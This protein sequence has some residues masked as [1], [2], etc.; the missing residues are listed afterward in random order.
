L[1]PKTDRTGRV[2]EN[3]APDVIEC[4]G[5]T[6]DPDPAAYEPPTMAG[7]VDTSH[8]E[9]RSLARVPHVSGG[10]DQI[11]L[12][13]K[14]VLTTEGTLLMYARCPRYVDEVGRGNLTLAQEAEIL[15]VLPAF[16]P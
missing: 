10:P 5:R 11:H 4:D 1:R 7:V 14:D 15:E 9:S 12:A 6:P 16:C 8:L 3:G 13:L 2:Y